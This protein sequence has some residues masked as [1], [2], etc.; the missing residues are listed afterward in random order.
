M[1]LRD[2]TRQDFDAILALNAESVHFL[3]PLNAAGLERLHAQAAFHR[4]IEIE[5]RIAGFLLALREGADYDSPN[6]LWF[7]QT[8]PVFLYID[9]VVVSIDHQG[10][11]LG[12][13]LYDALFAFARD[14]G[15]ARIA[16]EFD[17]EPPNEPSR[18]F[19]SR[20]GF[21]EV[22]RQR[23]GGGK[24]LVSLQVAEVGPAAETVLV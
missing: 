10:R 7:T 9:R 8:Y 17:I 2:A 19:H 24:K 12:A 13:L 6:Y 14:A 3:S 21:V 18:K 16:C 11:R 20:Y 15:M 4:V 5:G 22:G 23:A 1:T